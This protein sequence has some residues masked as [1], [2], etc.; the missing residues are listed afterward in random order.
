MKKLNKE[1]IEKCEMCGMFTV[2]TIKVVGPKGFVHLCVSCYN[3]FFKNRYKKSN[4]S[5]EHE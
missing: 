3:K 2:E 5:S 1:K 4:R